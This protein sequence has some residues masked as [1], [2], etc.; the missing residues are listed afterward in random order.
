MEFQYETMGEMIALE[1]FK[2]T[3]L[4][5]TDTKSG[6]TTA[7]QK[8]ELTP[9]VVRFGTDKIKAGSTVFVRGDLCASADAKLIYDVDGTKV[10]FLPV[11]EVKVVRTCTT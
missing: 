9:L 5:R 4:E 3:A 2:T 7:K 10:I 8:V 6:F 1:P 11:R